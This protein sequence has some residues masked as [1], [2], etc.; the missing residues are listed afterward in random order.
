LKHQLTPGQK[1][2][3][4]YLESAI[5]STGGTPSLRQ[6]A[7]DLG[8]SHATVSQHL[9]QLEQ[10]GVARRQGRYSRTIHLI[11][12]TGETAAVQRWV[13]VP[14]V[15]RVNAGL[16]LYAQQEWEGSLVLDKT[17]YRGR[18]LF[19]LRVRG[20]SM[21]GAGILDKDMAIC[22]PR[23]NAENGEIVVA[24]VHE[25]EATVKRFFLRR[26]HVELQPENPDY[27]VMRFGF[28]E[29]LV[30]GKVIGIQRGEAGI[31]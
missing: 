7:C 18:N 17:M 1:R 20:D 13:E 26:D 9:K 22:T 14:V 25:E 6:A 29:V 4:D 23:Q 15:G 10:K 5:K 28:D 30:Q 3:F 11:G 24:L 27:P 8:I 31:R 21:Q 19:A 12:P 16:P 2:L